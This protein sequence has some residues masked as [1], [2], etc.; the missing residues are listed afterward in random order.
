MGPRPATTSPLGILTRPRNTCGR[1][2]VALSRTRCYEQIVSDEISPR[3]HLF[4]MLPDDLL[5]FAL[6]HGLAANSTHARRLLAHVISHGERDLAPK[7]ELSSRL[8]RIVAEHTRMD[9]LEVLEK[10]EDPFD[11]FVKY[12]FRAPDGAVFESVRIPLEKPGCFTICISSQVGCAMKCDFCATG[13]LGLTRNLEP[14]EMVA[15]VLQIRDEAPGRVTGVVFMGQGEPFHNYDNVIQ[16]AKVLSEP[17]GGRIAADAITISTVGLVPQIRRYTAEGHRFKMIVSLTSSIAERRRRLL[18]VAGRFAMEDLADA[19]RQYAK[20]AKGR[21]TL[22]WV[23]MSGVNTDK[24]EVTEL[25]RLFG[26]L[27]LRIN[28]IDINDAREDGYKRASDAER[29]ALMDHLQVLGVPIVRRYSGGTNRHAA[30]GM[31]AAQRFEAEQIP[32]TE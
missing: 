26:D 25:Q 14:W 22:A 21:M 6:K 20:Q 9:R 23:V 19:V 27:P 29:R 16:A 28:L 8:V 17:C 15:Q 18:P 11:H 13:R 32:A 1:D 5:A 12:L 30:C 10:S 7:R 31:L 4:G 2:A 3:P 24:A